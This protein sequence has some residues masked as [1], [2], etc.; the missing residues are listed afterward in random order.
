MKP[1]NFPARV[2]RRQLL[3]QGKDISK[4]QQQLAEARK[5]KTKKYRGA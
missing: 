1:K 2:L 3:A 5:K 4:Y